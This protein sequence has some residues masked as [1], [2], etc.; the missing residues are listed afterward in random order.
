MLAFVACGASEPTPAEKNAELLKNEQA[1]SVK[2]A[3]LEDEVMLAFRN[4]VGLYT[5]TGVENSFKSP[6]G[7]CNVDSVFGAE[8]PQDTDQI[9]LYDPKGRGGVVLGLF[10]G[11]RK[12][13]CIAVALKALGWQQDPPTSE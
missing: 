5:E 2:Q 13:D 1:A 11:T 10:V 6:S 4:K 12:G 7:P 8:G 3:A 9:N